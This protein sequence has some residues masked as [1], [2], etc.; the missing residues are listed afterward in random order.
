MVVLV[1]VVLELVSLILRMMMSESEM[2]LPAL[3]TAQREKH[4]IVVMGRRR[5][6]RM[7]LVVTGWCRGCEGNAMLGWSFFGVAGGMAGQVMI[8]V[9]WEGI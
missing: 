5:T 4:R 7:V 2:D 6:A 8:I 3:R 1:L 9:G